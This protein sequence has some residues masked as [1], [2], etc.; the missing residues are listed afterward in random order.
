MVPVRA[1]LLL[2]LLLVGASA[3]HSGQE[4][5][6]IVDDFCRGET[7]ELELTERALKA[8]RTDTFLG[9]PDSSAL[10]RRD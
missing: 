8:G 1:K 9:E 7:L 2:P 3:C 5:S 4:L 6:N 10:A